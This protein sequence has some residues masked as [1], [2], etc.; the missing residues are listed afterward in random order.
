LPGNDAYSWVLTGGCHCSWYRWNKL[1]F[2]QIVST[3]APISNRYLLNFF[4]SM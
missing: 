3:F 4:V 1:L 2:R